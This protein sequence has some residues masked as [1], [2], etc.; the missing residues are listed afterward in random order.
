MM[1]KEMILI[2]IFMIMNTFVIMGILLQTEKDL[3]EKQQNPERI[4]LQSGENE[5][6]DVTRPM[7][8]KSGNT[9]PFTISF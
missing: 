4:L 9:K 2:S 5:R 7:K 8:E 1:I 6:R 3:R